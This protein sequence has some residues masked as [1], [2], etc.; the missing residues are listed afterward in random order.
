M[1]LE[2]STRFVYNRRWSLLTVEVFRVRCGT[3]MVPCLFN[4]AFSFAYVMQ[5]PVVGS[6]KGIRF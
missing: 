5:R 6:I 3:R 1:T 2:V 4:D